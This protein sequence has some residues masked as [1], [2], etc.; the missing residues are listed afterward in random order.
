MINHEKALSEYIVQSGVTQYPVGF[1]FHYNGDDTPQVAVTI[2]TEVPSLNRH[3]KFS[4]DLTAVILM[5]TEE[6][7]ELLSGPDDFSWMDKWVGMELVI[8]RDIPF[9][10]ESDYQLGRISPERIEKDFDLAVMRDQMLAD[11]IGEHTVDVQGE[12]DAINTRI[13]D[14]DEA[15]ATKA[16]KTELEN[17]KTT[18]NAGI[19][20]NAQAIQK[21][22]D[23]Y[24][25]A[26]QSIR[27][28]MNAKDSELETILNDHAERLDT[29]RTDHDDLGDDVS[30]IQAKIP[31]S[32]SD[33]NP[34]VTKQQ[35]L[36]E[37][38]DIREDLNGGL[39]ELQTQIT[40]QAAE[41][42]GKQNK[43]TAGDNIIIS[44]DVISATGA[45]GGAGLSFIVYDTLPETGE[46][47]IIYLVPKDSEAPDVYNE[48]VWITATQTFELIGNTQ[49]D[50]ADYATKG[51]LAGYL[52]VSG[53]TMTGSIVS[54]RQ[55]DPDRNAFT[56]L[57]FGGRFDNG[58]GT[59]GKNF[60]LYAMSLNDGLYIARL[61]DGSDTTPL[62]Y[63]FFFNINGRGSNFSPSVSGGH[64]SLGTS[65]YR[66]GTIY[67]TE[68]AYRNNIIAV[69][70]KAGTMAL[71]EDLENID[72]L[73]D[74]TGNAGKV[75]MT[76]GE[77]ASWQEPA[78]GTKVIF[79]E[80]EE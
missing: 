55:A 76:D 61:K 79:R 26:D 3:Y 54:E 25:A 67:V 11:K 71:L 16:T 7:A 60:G 9:V 53:G 46:S 78:G 35:L 23:D 12:I 45:G 18:L 27:A 49:V 36:D 70:D 58:D 31:E 40:H 44:G 1:V 6:E 8:K 59:F 39:S 4:D 33:S 32:A 24:Q 20:G 52:P 15:L 37:E 62:T 72:A 47:G 38:M 43:L 51:E 14:V 21:T 10:Q 69:P 57:V 34:L 13:D 17:A 50:L 2:G 5:P 30:D 66:W 74:Q 28:D 48:Y 63:G 68:I 73:P 77:Q 42:A 29:L 56:Q 22:R 64:F 80:W 75:L 65:F 41:I 19:Q